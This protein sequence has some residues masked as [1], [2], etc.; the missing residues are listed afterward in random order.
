MAQESTHLFVRKHYFSD[1]H[2][3][4]DYGSTMGEKYCKTHFHRVNLKHCGCRHNYHYLE[5]ISNLC[6]LLHP[7]TLWNASS[8]IYY[9]LTYFHGLAENTK[10]HFICIEI[11]CPCNGR[12]CH[13]SLILYF[14]K[15][16]K[17][18]YHTV[19][20][21]SSDSSFSAENIDLWSLHLSTT[22]K[23]WYI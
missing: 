20:T 3:F 23:N 18:L 19:P 8:K 4:V 11:Q 12:T 21:P 9:P 5:I 22:S 2:T 10:V 16:F 7:A 6:I 17:L 14:I 13:V 15:A 1:L